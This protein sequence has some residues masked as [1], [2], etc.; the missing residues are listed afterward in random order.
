MEFETVY[1]KYADTDCVKFLSESKYID[2]FRKNYIDFLKILE[3]SDKTMFD[4]IDDNNN[5]LFRLLLDSIVATMIYFK[6]QGQVISTTISLVEGELSMDIDEEDFFIFS[7]D[8][9]HIT[10]AS[11]DGWSAKSLRREFFDVLRDEFHIEDPNFLYPN[12]T[13]N[14]ESIQCERDDIRGFFNEI[15][16][17]RYDEIIRT[18]VEV[19]DYILKLIDLKKIDIRPHYD[20]SNFCL[21]INGNIVCF[22]LFVNN[23]KKTIKLTL[24]L[25][26]PEGFMIPLV[27]LQDI[28]LNLCLR[29]SSN[30]LLL[31]VDDGNVRKSYASLQNKISNTKPLLK[32]Y[33]HLEKGGSA[34]L[35]MGLLER[36]ITGLPI[37]DERDA[38]F[39]LKK[40][41]I[42]LLDAYI[43]FISTDTTSRC[44]ICDREFIVYHGAQN[45]LHGTN[46]TFQ[47][48]AFLSTNDILENS[49]K[50]CWQGR[51]DLRDTYSDWFSISSPERR[52]TVANF[53]PFR[54]YDK[55]VKFVI[56]KFEDCSYKQLCL[57]LFQTKSR[58]AKKRA[59]MCERL[60]SVKTQRTIVLAIE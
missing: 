54:N 42:Q 60:S 25:Q 45:P 47:C 36:I 24:P 23:A 39:D 51:C 58:S 43:N 15:I 3:P 26:V 14:R 59:A 41:A 44:N 40:R 18:T 1:Q 11:I 8:N 34:R 30:S 48:M 7:I 35:N 16:S 37:D 21:K 29:M 22:S 50:I 57:R 6:K 19:K 2:K 27:T 53:T 33:A 13:V 56:D 32:L 46:D 49:R 12:P 9:K 5:D 55:V 28:N 17:L 20:N 31:V 4:V 38:Q 52:E 10:N